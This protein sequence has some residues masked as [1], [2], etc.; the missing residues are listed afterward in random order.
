MNFLAAYKTKLIAGGIGIAV[1]VVAFNYVRD[2]RT[3]LEQ[4]KTR[5]ATL[6]QKFQ[7]LTPSTAVSGN[8]I[9]KQKPAAST[10]D[11][12]LGPEF[13]AWMRQNNGVLLNL[14]QSIGQVNARLVALE[15]NLN[16]QSFTASRQQNGAL[17]GFQIEQVRTGADG[18]P[19]PAL[20]AVN[21]SYDPTQMDVNAAFRGTSFLNYQ[22]RFK[23]SFATVRDT[24][25]GAFATVVSL[26]R[27]VSRPDPAHPGQLLPVGTEDIPL[28]GSEATFTP[29]GLQQSAK[30]PR[31]TATFGAGKA[32][33]SVKGY[34]P[35]GLIDYRV[36]DRF[37]VAGGVANGG[38]IGGV[39][40]RFGAPK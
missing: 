12:A 2:L 13:A 5:Q 6:E 32:S 15:G 34:Q 36:T 19:L 1:L 11:A 23:P 24:K 37:G 38:L 10:A 27:D 26:K 4:A 28:V 35:A 8:S 17:T 21:V 14:T 22:E 30:I 3:E 20:T 25:T 33:G 18:R 29:E 7:N 40:F 39:S 9:E 31:W 16:Q